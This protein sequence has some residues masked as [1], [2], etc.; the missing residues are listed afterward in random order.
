MTKNKQD[1]HNHARETNQRETEA[2][3]QPIET[4]RRKVRKRGKRKKMSV[5][6]VFVVPDR[7]TRYVFSP[8][9]QQYESVTH[10]HV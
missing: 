5:K 7:I 6:D 8:D 2:E 3:H 1:T 10:H 9:F 4:Y